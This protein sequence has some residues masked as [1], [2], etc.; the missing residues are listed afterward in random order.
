[1]RKI[2]VTLLMGAISFPFTQLLFSDLPG[3]IAAAAVFGSV[4]LVVQFLIDFERRLGRVEDS[5]EDAVKQIRE[6]VRQGFARVNDATELVA[7]METAGMQSVAV[8][9]LVRHA[10]AISPHA[11]ALVRDF[12]QLEVDR[13]SELLRGL[14]VNEATYDGEDQDWLLNLTKCAKSSIDAISIPEVDAAGNTYH[15]FWAS[16]LGIRYLDTQRGAVSRGVRIRR[17]FVTTHD[18]VAHDP[19]LHGICQ[20][21]VDS[22]I[23]VRLLYPSAVPPEIRGQIT[24]FILFDNEICYETNPVP[25]VDRGAAP[26]IL[27]NHLELR[28]HRLQDRTDRYK[29][30]WE[31]ASPW[32]EL[33]APERVLTAV[34]DES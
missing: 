22:G 29:I 15:S 25:H 13:V 24:D 23:E 2:G 3:Q 11:P 17:V 30:I 14:T 26:M 4:A 6:T 5:L 7:R 31:S 27:S 33:M 32:D 18:D 16:P 34:P 28:D 21:Q 12:V 8:T 19:V 1:M 20:S 9:E 10:A